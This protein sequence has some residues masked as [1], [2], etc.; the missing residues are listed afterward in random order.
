MTEIFSVFG[1]EYTNNYL[2]YRAFLFLHD[3]LVSL[4]WRGEDL[5]WLGSDSAFPPPHPPHPPGT[6]VT[7]IHPWHTDPVRH[8]NQS[9]AAALQQSAELHGL[10]LRVSADCIICSIL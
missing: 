6:D 7:Y 10:S 8:A 5:F 4:L 2:G 9:A 3:C 1:I